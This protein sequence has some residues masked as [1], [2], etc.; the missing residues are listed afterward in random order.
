MSPKQKTIQEK[1]RFRKTSFYV[2]QTKNYLPSEKVKGEPHRASPLISSSFSDK[3]RAVRRLNASADADTN[4]VKRLL[5]EPYTNTCRFLK[6][7][8]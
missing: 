1:N 6:Q 3:L 8:R 4:T 7:L 2:S 5:G